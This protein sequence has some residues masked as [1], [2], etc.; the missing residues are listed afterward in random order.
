MRKLRNILA[1]IACK[2]LIIAGKLAGKKGSSAPGGFALKVSPYILK[3]LAKQVK[4]EI[5][6]VC[7][8]NGKTTTNNLLYTL[9]KSKGYSVVGNIVGANMLP[10]IACSFI[11]H[12]SIFGK[13]KA[14]YA[15]IECDEASLRRVVPHLTPDKVVIT[16]LFRDQLDRYGEVDITIS[17]LNEALDKLS[18]TELI[19]NGDDPLSAHFGKGKKCVYFGVDEKCTTSLRETKE[20]RYCAECGEELNYNYSHYSQLGDY[21]C[22]KCGFKRP[23]LDYAAKNVNLADGLKFTIYN[24]DKTYPLNLNYRGFYNIYNILASV[25]V[26]NECNEDIS[27]LE[28]VFAAYK[29][30][31]AR[32]EPFN[33]NGKTVI[34]NLAKNPAGFNQA[35]ATVVSDPRKKDVMIALNDGPG[36]G[37]DISWIWDVDFEKL[38]EANLTSLTASGVR[39]NDLALRLKYAGF[40]DVLSKENNKQTLAEVISG[41]G[42]IAYILVNYTAMFGTQTNLKSLEGNE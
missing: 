21:L 4:K 9:L 25:A 41:D 32:M 36:D 5:I 16:N 33:V 11:D 29:P 18:D 35:I 37:L 20:G 8:T 6:V 26:L 27:N 19:L 1:I 34:L 24:K 7:G 13:L 31:V 39:L 30:Q 14:D 40:E 3:D 10:G 2:L 23:D 42:E 28:S 15:T 22:P 17:L 12:A 38:S